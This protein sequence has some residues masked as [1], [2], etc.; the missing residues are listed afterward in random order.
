M[1][2]IV[3]HDYNLPE[4]VDENSLVILSSYSGTTEE[5]LATAQQAAAKQSKIAGITEGRDLG[6]F[7]KSRQLPFY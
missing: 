6:E 3:L 4:F 5:V 2:L 1:P 7:L